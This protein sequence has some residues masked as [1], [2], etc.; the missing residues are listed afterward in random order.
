MARYVTLAREAIVQAAL[1]PA[2]WH[3]TVHDDEYER[4]DAEGA[5]L[6]P[7]PA[8]PALRRVIRLR[9]AAEVMGAG[10]PEGWH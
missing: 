9:T 1:R 4:L 2:G 7:E 8:A 6:P 5:F 10:R 3:G